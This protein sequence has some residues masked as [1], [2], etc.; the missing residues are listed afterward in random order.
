[1]VVVLAR[2][3]KIHSGCRPRCAAPVGLD[4]RP[5]DVH[6]RVAGHL[7]REQRRR[8]GGSLGGDHGEAFMQVGVPGRTAQR[9]VDSQLR[10]PGPLGV[11]QARHEQHGVVA[12]RQDSTVCDTHS[13][14]GPLVMLIC[15][16]TNVL[17]GFCALSLHHN[18][19]GRVHTRHC[20][21]HHPERSARADLRRACH[22]P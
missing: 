21:G 4:Q 19:S 14:A 8:Q 7:R 9:V 22:R 18:K 5:V 13:G 10:D 6:V 12:Y 1:M 3:P 16:R 2:P 20:A 15:E 17:P 11:Q